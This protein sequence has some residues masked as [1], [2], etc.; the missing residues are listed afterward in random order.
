MDNT[1]DLLN[2][3]LHLAKVAEEQIMPHFNACHIKIKADGT[4]VTEADRKAEEKMVE[5]IAQRFP[6]HGILGEEFGEVEKRDGNYKWI[7]DPLD[8]T[9]WFTLGIPIFGTLIG[10]IKNDKPII[11]V[12]HFPALGETVYA[13][14]GGGCWFKRNQSSPLRINVRPDVPLKDAVVSAAGVHSTSVFAKENE[15]PYNLPGLISRVGKFRF[16]GDCLQHALVCRGKVHLAVD[17]IMK[18]W[19]T[20]AII[21]CIEEAGGYVSTLSGTGDNII[22]GGSLISSC[23]DSLNREALRVLQPVP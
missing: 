19:D 17:T 22:Y 20:A 21:P 23:S 3:A 16:C 15:T 14:K 6:R 10:V 8:G 1:D 9:A 2:F 18:P 11:G 4:E 5:Q 7:I 12:I 13:A